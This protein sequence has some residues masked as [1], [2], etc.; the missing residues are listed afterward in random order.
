MKERTLIEDEL[1]LRAINIESDRDKNLRHGHVSTMHLWWAPR[2]LPMS[3]AVVFSSLVPTPEDEEERKE[4]M[5]VLADAMPFERALQSQPLD[6]L[7]AELRHAW[8]DNPPKVLDC[9]A[10]RGIIPLEAM[11]LGCDVTAV[12]LNPVAHLIEL[13]ILEF[14]Q[15]WNDTLPDGRYRL[16]V[17]FLKCAH[18][19][20]EI[21]ENELAPHFPMEGGDRP[22][23]YFWARTMPCSEP[24]CH[25]AIPLIKS[26]KLANSA[27][28]T[29]RLDFD[30][31]P[32]RIDVSVH[33]GKPRDGSDWSTGTIRGSVG[34]VPSLRHHSIADGGKEVRQNR[35]I[36]LHAFCCDDDI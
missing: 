2:P 34:L 22:A 27:K 6:Q 17:D 8:P 36:R 5:R 33:E 32:D 31:E 16:I 7:R 29:V 1:P 3:R 30:I 26:R 20:R 24:T 25:R 21:A 23:T 28:R 4:L 13:S 12:D 19:M 10:G 14:P 35:R 15:R 11:R 18:R 9:F